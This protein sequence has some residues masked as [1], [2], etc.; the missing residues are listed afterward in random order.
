MH[1]LRAHNLSIKTSTQ[2][3]V[4]F[5]IMGVFKKKKANKAQNPYNTFYFHTYKCTGNTAHSIPNQN[6]KKSLAN[7]GK[8]LLHHGTSCFHCLTAIIAG[9]TQNHW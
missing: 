5:K 1:L 8:A 6:M 4:V 3:T 2:I 9:G 7:Y